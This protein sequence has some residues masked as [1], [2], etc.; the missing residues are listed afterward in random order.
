MK[1]RLIYQIR[2][3]CV[4]RRNREGISALASPTT[5]N[6]NWPHK[7]SCCFICFLR[8]GV[9]WRAWPIP[10]INQ[11]QK[12]FCHRNSRIR[13]NLIHFKDPQLGSAVTHLDE[14]GF[15]NRASALTRHVKQNCQEPIR[16]M[17]WKVTSW[18]SF[19]MDH[20]IIV[21]MSWFVI[22]CFVSAVSK[23]VFPDCQ[24]TRLLLCQTRPFV[25]VVV[26]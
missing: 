23:C 19:E 4:D 3:N 24:A 20:V 15:L 2:T 5:H 12:A 6:T 16:R 26:F 11:H 7:T 18:F 25:F 1:Q 9:N 13:F 21:D 22:T 8:S 10:K 14:W 17:R